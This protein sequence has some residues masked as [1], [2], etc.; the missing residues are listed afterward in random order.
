M[1]AVA[2]LARLA[3]G[4]LI[5]IGLGA[6]AAAAAELDG[7]ALFKSACATCHAAQRNAGHRQGPNLFGV[8]GRKAGAYPGFA[9][10]PPFRAAA[11]GLAWNEATLDRWLT[12]SQAMIPG[13]AMPYKQPDA[14]RRAA[15]I[16]YLKTLK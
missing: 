6:A 11:R 12:D 5:A 2:T 13:A 14:T 3:K 9:Y 7:A 16:N 4:A 15:L 10:S 8:Y 1:T